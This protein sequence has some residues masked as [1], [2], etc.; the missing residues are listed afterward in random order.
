MSYTRN[1]EFEEK[2]GGKEWYNW[3]E[4]SI[5]TPR[6]RR[7]RRANELLRRDEDLVIIL[8]HLTIYELKEIH[9]IAKVLS[10]RIYNYVRKPTFSNIN[11]LRKITGI[12]PIR[13]KDISEY[14]NQKLDSSIKYLNR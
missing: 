12:G 7:E 1:V 10:G 14:V 5:D 3:E 9:G 2:E 4:N 13:F 8:Q 6:K 11:D